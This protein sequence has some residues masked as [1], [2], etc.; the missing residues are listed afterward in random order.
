MGWFLTKK[1]KSAPKPIARPV[2]SF[3]KPAPWD[4]TRTLL[5]IRL[6][7]GMALIVGLGTGWVFGERALTQY[8]DKLANHAAIPPEKVKLVNTPAWMSSKL[9]EEIRTLAASPV[10]DDPLDREG[11][12][13]SVSAVRASPWVAEVKRVQRTN[14]GELRVWAEY[15]SPVAAVE[16]EDGCRVVDATGIVLPGVYDKEQGH[17]LGIPLITRV[18]NPPPTEGTRWQGEDLKAGLVLLQ[19]L[20]GQPYYSQIRAFDV[21]DH[22]AKGRLRLSL[23]TR[24]G[25]VRWGLPIGEEQTIE[26]DPSV[27]RESIAAMQKQAGAIDAGGKIVDVFG[28]TVNV[29]MPATDDPAPQA[30]YT[31]GR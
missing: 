5:L 28:P 21:G 16:T 31:L 19:Y 1:K 9:Q 27:K 15:R 30:G 22:D 4:P 18:A 20:R 11:L 10:T 25:M 12:N 7:V 17:H 8:A 24:H 6:A 23:L 14:T 26:P 29:S 3:S 13:K 2:K